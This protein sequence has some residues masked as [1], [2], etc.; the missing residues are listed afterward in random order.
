MQKG[1]PYPPI[2]G[3]EPILLRIHLKNNQTFA[4][5]DMC[6]DLSGIKCLKLIGYSAKNLNNTD[7]LLFRF[8][9][10]PTVPS[11]SND[12]L[13]S[14]FP[15]IFDSVNETVWLNKPLPIT[16]ISHVFNGSHRLS[17]TVRKQDP[18]TPVIFSNLD[19]IF[20]GKHNFD[21]RESYY[22]DY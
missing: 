5:L 19:L 13:S 20:E 14:H 15:L 16:G 1:Y 12:N 4:E 9:N 8:N 11:Y 6:R 22:T 21:Q 10:Q 3:N 17:I 7:T 18:I 2:N